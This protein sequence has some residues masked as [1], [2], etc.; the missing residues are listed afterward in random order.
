MKY[1][2][3][4]WHYG[5]NFPT[6]LPM[7]AGAT[8]TGMFVAWAWLSGLAGEMILND[9]PNDLEILRSRSL[10]PGQFFLERCD[11]KFIDDD[12]NDEGNLFAQAYFDF[13]KGQYIKDYTATLGQD[14]Q[15]LYYVKDSW[16]NF[17]RLKPVLDRR[18]AEWKQL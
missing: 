13:E 5:G 3:A 18:F 4:S 1:D 17:D 15:N 8:H 6:D 10:V 11:G 16:E 9:F 12:L 2:D 14:V 7:E